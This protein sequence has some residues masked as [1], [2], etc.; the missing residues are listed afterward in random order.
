MWERSCY[1][2]FCVSKIYGITTEFDTVPHNIRQWPKSS[3]LLFCCSVMSDSFW[4]HEL[5][6]TSRPCPS[7]SPRACS[8]SCS[9]SQ[10]YYPTI[11]LILCCPP[12]NPTPFLRPSIF[13]SIRVFSTELTLPIRWPKYCSFSFNLSPP[14]EF[15][16]LISFRM[17][18]FDLLAVQGNV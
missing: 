16:G 4:P 14:N 10:W 17:N 18:W 13:P 9:L 5:Q 12:R 15:S 6:H 1:Q 7:L 11:Y 8:N 2:F 3:L